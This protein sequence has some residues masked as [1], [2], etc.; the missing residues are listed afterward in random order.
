MVWLF[1]P[2][3]FTPSLHRRLNNMRLLYQS[4]CIVVAIVLMKEQRGRSS[5]MV[6][7]APFGCIPFGMSVSC[8]SNASR[9]LPEA[10]GQ[11]L[12]LYHRGPQY[13]QV[14]GN[15]IHSEDVLIAASEDRSN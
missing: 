14:D 2:S 5:F 6:A 8:P 15:R 10:A 7:S 12:R 9:F 4:V 3:V 1:V 11:R 13:R